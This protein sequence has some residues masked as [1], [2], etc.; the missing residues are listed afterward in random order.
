[1]VRR[2]QPHDDLIALDRLA[3]G[4]GDL[5]DGLVGLRDEFDPVPLQGSHRG[6]G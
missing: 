2:I 1:M 4:H 5:D 3:F 6:Q